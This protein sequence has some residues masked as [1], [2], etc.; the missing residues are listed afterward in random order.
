MDIAINRERLAET[1]IL[2]CE[3]DSPS[4]HE[5]AIADYLKRLL[6][7]LGAAS[8]EEDD[9]AAQTGSDSGNLLIR[10]QGNQPGR[11]GFFFSCHMDTVQPGE[12]VRVLLNEDYVFTSAGDTILGGDDKSGIAAIIETMRLLKETGASHPDIEILITTCEEVGLLGAKFFDTKKVRGHYGY[13]LDSSGIDRVIVGAPAANKFSIEIT[14]VSAHAGLQPEMGISAIAV[15]AKAISQIKLGRLDAESTANFG[16][17]TGGVATNIVPERVV[18]DGEVRSHNPEKLRLYS[19]EIEKVFYETAAAWPETMTENGPKRPTVAINRMA[20]YPALLLAPE[21]PALR[22]IQAAGQVLG[23]T[24]EF[25][26]AGGGSDANIF[27]DKGLPTAIVATGM[28]L[29][30]TTGER[31][32]LDDLV[33]LTRLLFAIATVD[34]D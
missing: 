26:I 17:I 30:H 23:K 21:A 7:E 4:G 28:D 6:T 13:A 24:L 10:F 33:E 16:V 31:L 11:D 29:V 22:R 8:V 25:I 27:G 1:F 2:L 9:S 3:I 15:A 34:G 5:R 32:R 14:G 19:D 12:G 20:E 18:I